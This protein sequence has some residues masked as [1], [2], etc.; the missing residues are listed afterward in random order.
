MLTDIKNN[1]LDSFIIYEDFLKRYDYIDR[2]PISG[3]G[4]KIVRWILPEE[5]FVDFDFLY[6]GDVDFLILKEPISII[7]YHLTHIKKHNIPFSNHLRPDIYLNRPKRLTGGNHFIIRSPYYKLLGETIDKMQN[8]AYLCDYLN[9]LESP[10]AYFDAY[11][12]NSNYFLKDPYLHDRNN[13]EHFLY[14]LISSKIDISCLENESDSRQ[15]HGIHLGAGRE[16]NFSIE[17]LI[18]DSFLSLDECKRQVEEMLEDK[19]FRYLCIT[20]NEKSIWRLCRMLNVKL[21]GFRE[22]MLKLSTD[23]HDVAGHPGMAARYILK[24]II[25]KI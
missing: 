16:R 12:A 13:N 9:Y 17:A 14:R 11:G 4:K 1:G 19:L 18:T 5:Y 22:K 8:P 6:I 3:G 10:K 25:R 23:I 21:P 20:L 24:T 15:W 2:Y 7:D